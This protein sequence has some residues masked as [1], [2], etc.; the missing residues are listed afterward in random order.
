MR[1]HARTAWRRITAAATLA[2]ACTLAAAGCGAPGGLHDDGRTRAVASHPTPLA[3]WPE[4][5]T[6]AAPTATAPVRQAAPQP[7]PGVTVPSGDIRAV[8]AVNVLD[9]DP[10]LERDER[11]ALKGCPTCDVRPARYRDLTGDGRPELI[12]SLVTRG[13]RASLH[14]Y[15]L[16]GEKVVPVLDLLPLSPHFTADTVGADLVVQEPTTASL[17][18]SSRYRW[19]GTRLAFTTRQIKATGPGS[20]IDALACAP[21]PTDLPTS[22]PTPVPGPLSDGTGSGPGDRGRGTVGGGQVP[23]ASPSGASLTRPVTR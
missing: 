4:T 17:E 6:P 2:V 7:V 16:R 12:T 19:D 14:V 3:L 1:T 9:R 8:S 15:A 13:D 18:T 11:A 22:A 5:A 20:S 10:A 21:T 23:S